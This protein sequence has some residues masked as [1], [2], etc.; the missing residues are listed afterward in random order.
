MIKAGLSEDV[1]W[2]RSLL[3][4]ASLLGSVTGMGSIDN[5]KM[6]TWYL[7]K[8]SP[9]MRSQKFRYVFVDGNIYKM[10]TKESKKAMTVSAK[11]AELYNWYTRWLH[12]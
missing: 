9:S 7:Y 3:K 1:H 6:A 8:P 11:E 12:G 5:G 10:E 4:P 2:Q